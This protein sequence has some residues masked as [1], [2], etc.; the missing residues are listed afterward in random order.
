MTNTDNNIK[1]VRF[2]CYGIAT[3]FSDRTDNRLIGVYDDKL[4]LR[5]HT[6]LD[7]EPEVLNEIQMIV[8]YIKD[9][10]VYN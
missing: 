5:I 1:Y 4:G 10:K 8:N 3:V 7:V 2:V 9:E 6:K